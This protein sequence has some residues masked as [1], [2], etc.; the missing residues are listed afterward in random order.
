MAFDGGRQE[1][2]AAMAFNGTT[3]A[4]IAQLLGDD[5][6]QRRVPVGIVVSAAGLTLALSLLMCVGQELLMRVM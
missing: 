1:T 2:P 4:R 3:R 6:P 5:P